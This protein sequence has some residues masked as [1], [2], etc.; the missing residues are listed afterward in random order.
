MLL[1]AFC[2]FLLHKA[3]LNFNSVLEEVS[4]TNYKQ[5]WEW[6]SNIVSVSMSTKTVNPGHAC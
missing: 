3:V 6:M 2:Q 5:F 4:A 1:L